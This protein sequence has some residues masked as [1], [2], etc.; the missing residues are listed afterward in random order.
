MNEI[1]D[2]EY[3]RNMAELRALSSLSLKQPLTDK[4][5]ERMMELAKKLNLK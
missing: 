3:M 1:E 4:Q 2:F 5:E